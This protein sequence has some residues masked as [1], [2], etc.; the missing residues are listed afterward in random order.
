MVKKTNRWK[1]IN[2]GNYVEKNNPHQI[3]NNKTN[4]MLAKL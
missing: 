2:W 1:L 4:P 3:P